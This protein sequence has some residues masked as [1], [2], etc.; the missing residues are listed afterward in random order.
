RDEAAIAATVD[1]DPPRIDI[2]FVFQ[3]ARRVDLIVEVL[4][5]HVTIDCGAPVATVAARS[6]VIDVE[7]EIAARHQHV[8]EHVLAEIARPPA[9]NILQISGAV[10]EDDRRSTP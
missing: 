9:V 3:P 6:A 8:M 2:L 5:A 1:S 7:H 4:A 10:Y